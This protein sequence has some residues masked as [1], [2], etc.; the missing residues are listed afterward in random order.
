[1]DG[2][3]ESVR[4]GVEASEIDFRELTEQAG[5]P[6]VVQQGERI[7]YANPATCQLVGAARPRDLIGRSVLEFIPPENVDYVVATMTAV[8]TAGASAPATEQDV[9]RLDGSRVAVEIIAS[10]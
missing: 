6:I 1:M 3:G 9:L 5:D 7:V 4:P 10:P 8:M 2:S